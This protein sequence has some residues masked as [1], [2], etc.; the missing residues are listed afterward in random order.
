MSGVV[1][2]AIYITLGQDLTLSSWLWGGSHYITY[3]VGGRERAVEWGSEVVVALGM[4][5]HC[6]EM[7]WTCCLKYCVHL[8]QEC[9]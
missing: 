5:L 3:K 4:S 7:R 6:T 9:A 8:E 1:C 2:L